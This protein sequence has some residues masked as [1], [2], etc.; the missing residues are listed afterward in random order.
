M[1]VILMSVCQLSCPCALD[2]QVTKLNK[3]ENKNIKGKARMLVSRKLPNLGCTRSG[4]KQRHSMKK[5]VLTPFFLNC[6]L[7]LCL[8][9]QISAHS[10]RKASLALSQVIVLLSIYILT[11]K[12]CASASYAN[13]IMFLVYA[14]FLQAMTLSYANDIILC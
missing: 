10:Y 14:F 5:V 11:I 13:D 7:K 9:L 1:F 2:K 12:Y 3:L 4:G 6:K 8:K